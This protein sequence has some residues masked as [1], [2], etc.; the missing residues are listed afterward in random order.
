MDI[1]SRSF[2][3][4]VFK[5][6]TRSLRHKP[7]SPR[8]YP[9]VNVND[10]DLNPT[11]YGF[12]KIRPPIIAQSPTETLFPSFELAKKYIEAGKRVPNRFTDKRTPEQA[13]EE[14]ESFQEKLALDEPHFTIG[15]KQIY[16]PYGRVCLLRSNAKHTPYQAKFLVPKAMNKM[17][18]RDYLWH[19]Y[20]LRAL[21]ITVQL[22]PG[23]WKRGP[24]D[25]GRYRAPQLKKMTVDMA[26]PFIWP[27]VPQATVDRIQNMHQTSR[28]VMEKN[29]AQGSNKNKPLEACDGI[30]K[31]K[32]VPSVF[33]SQQFKRE[34]RR[35]IDKYNKVVG[36]K[37]NRAALESFLGL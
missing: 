36:A 13:R 25:L 3:N 21:N 8:R 17:D 10:V 29:M 23:T 19:I 14:F 15:G 2:V 9:K 18:L 20:G 34:Q 30:Y 33:I 22:Q 37:K 12:R 24:N 26:E 27:E 28:K 32:E 1:Q 6:F 4:T 7:L 31:E 5:T 35:S 11:R 16:F